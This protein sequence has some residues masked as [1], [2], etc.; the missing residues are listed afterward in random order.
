MPDNPS[1][2]SYD[3]LQAAFDANDSQ[4]ISD[5]LSTTEPADARR[6][7]S[8]LSEADQSKLLESLSLRGRGRARRRPAGI[9]GRSNDRAAVGRAG[10]AI[11]SE[12]PSDEQAD[13]I[14]RLPEVEA[15]AIL[16]AMPADEARDARR[17]MSYPPDSAGGLMIT[18]YLSYRDNLTVGDVLDD[19]RAHADRYR[20]FDV[21][22]AYV[23]SDDG[24]LV[25]VLR[26]RDLLLSPPGQSLSAVMIHE[27]LKVRDTRR[28]EEL[29]RFFDRHP[30]FG[31]PA[32]D[33]DGVLVG[34]VRSADVEAGGRGAVEPQLFE[35]H[36]HRRR[37]GAADD[38]AATS[39]ACG[40]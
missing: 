36:G 10:G 38:A 5:F 22:Y 6:S 32:V 39:A 29:E 16:D 24:K 21:Q 27:P 40:G 37:R 7:I 30:L 19:L 23:V 11:V 13:V 4:A 9:A 34:V 18:E 25:G 14:S 17:L 35:I 28:L 8:Q 12:L 15:S 26:L 1:R 31:V 3:P 2:K 20:S 33:A